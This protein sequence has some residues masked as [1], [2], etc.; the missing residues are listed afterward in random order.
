MTY[1]G[2]KSNEAKLEDGTPILMVARWGNN[3]QKYVWLYPSQEKLDEL[4]SKHGIEQ[5][6]D[7]VI[8]NDDGT[9]TIVDCLWLESWR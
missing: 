9:R 7:G 6:C 2:K 8:R 5:V 4:I 3:G 1:Y